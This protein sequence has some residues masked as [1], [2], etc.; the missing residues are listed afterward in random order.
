MRSFALAR[1]LAL[2]ALVAA[3]G[4]SDDD[5]SGPTRSA[6][7]VAAT[8][9]TTDS[10]PAPTDDNAA[11]TSSTGAVPTTEGP[12]PTSGSD[13]MPM[14]F[15]AVTDGSY[16]VVEV[17]VASGEILQNL[18]GWG[19]E[20]QAVDVVDLGADGSL[21]LS[22][23][24]EPA[25]G[26]RYRLI[27]PSDFDPS[28]QAGLGVGHA[29]APDGDTVAFSELGQVVVTSADG[30]EIGRYPD[31]MG[32]PVWLT[33]MTWLDDTRL[34]VGDAAVLM[35][36]DTSTMDVVSQWEAAGQVW[37]AA[38]RAD[39]MLFTVVGWEGTDLVGQVFDPAA[40]LEVAE[41]DL[42]DDAYEIDYDPTGTYLLVVTGSGLRWYG[43]GSEGDLGP[44]YVSASW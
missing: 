1:V 27:P 29:V 10:S 2:A 11:T 22:D 42:P 13:E 12:S 17:D 9:S 37:D 18:G 38:T 30:T 39:G 36:L 6:D 26:N 20:E 25:V 15:W 43:A 41:I 3:C 16:E 31:T 35:V 19:R 32:G 33:P 21:W 5:A 4:S 40:A 34:V 28:D 23:C 14:T 24:C 7:S 44:G 8:S